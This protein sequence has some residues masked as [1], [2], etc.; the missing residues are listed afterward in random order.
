MSVGDGVCWSGLTLGNPA[1]VVI[2]FAARGFAV[3]GV[4]SSNLGDSLVAMGKIL[5]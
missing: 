2:L 5:F 3:V 4:V 1:A